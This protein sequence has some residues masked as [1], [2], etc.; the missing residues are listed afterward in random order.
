MKSLVKEDSYKLTQVHALFKLGRT[1]LPLGNGFATGMALFS[2]MTLL[3]VLFVHYFS[4][5]IYFNQFVFLGLLFGVVSGLVFAASIMKGTTISAQKILAESK[6]QLKEIPYLLEGKSFPDMFKAGNLHAITSLKVLTIPSL[7]LIVLP[8]GLYFLLGIEF[9]AGYVIG[10]FVIGLSQAFSW[11]S[12][13]DIFQAIYINMMTGRLGGSESKVF[14]R[15]E[16][17]SQFTSVFNDSLSPS[18][19]ILLKTMPILVIFI[20]YVILK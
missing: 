1:V 14:K 15:I 3:M 6:R 10:V 11:A 13:G 17:N 19:N 20:D 7:W 12:F 5:G 8:I 18:F 16:S 4:S 2:S 9:L